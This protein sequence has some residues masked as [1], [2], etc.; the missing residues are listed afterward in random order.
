MSGNQDMAVIEI[1]HKETGDVLCELDPDDADEINLTGADLRNGD[2]SS[3]RLP[4]AFMTRAHLNSATLRGAVLDEASLLE[5][6]LESA[7]LSTA[8]FSGADLR[9]C[10]P[11]QS[12]IFAV[13]ISAVRT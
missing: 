9:F 8:V 12:R 11:D 10:Q 5:A 3:M 1:K 2:L 6:D 13:P 7:D 4:G